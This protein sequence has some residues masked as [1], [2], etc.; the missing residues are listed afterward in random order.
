MSTFAFPRRKYSPLNMIWCSLAV[1]LAYVFFTIVSG[2]ITQ[3]L[4]LPAP[5]I[6]SRVEPAQLM[7]MI[8]VSGVVIGFTLG[9]L[10]TRLALPLVERAGVLFVLIF[11]LN[12]L[13]NVI[14]ALFFTTF[15]TQDTIVGLPGI[16]LT[17]LLLAVLVAWVF[18]PVAPARHLWVA[19]GETL[20][21]RSWFDWVWR[22][23]LAGLL[24]VP[25]YLFF[26]FLI[27][28]IVTPYYNNP[29][30]GIG[31]V[32]PG[33]EVILPLEVVRG[34][35]YVLTMFPLV[36]LFRGSRWSLA[37]WIGLTIAVLGSW[38][39]MLQGTFL[40]VTLRLVHGLEITADAFVQGLTI[41]WLLGVQR[42]R[43]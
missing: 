15:V 12:S 34:L 24:Y 43:R 14:E 17:D 8:F 27:A 20:H 25:T 35:L 9:P 23:L 42:I 41:A 3:A 5:A 40:P 36:V 6:A 1:G 39:P 33:F 4:G 29:A 19:I 28:P 31:L 13:L 21:Q 16:L 11:M 38:T 10:S 18:L 7:L 22:F 26:G 30:L 37:F 2:M 32:I